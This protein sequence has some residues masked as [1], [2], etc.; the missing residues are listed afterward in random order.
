MTKTPVILVLRRYDEFGLLLKEAGYEVISLAVLKTKPTEDLSGLRSRLGKLSDYDGLFF[1]SPAAAEVFVNE[2]NEKNG[3][4]GNVY[5]LGQRA[6]SILEVAGYRVRKS[7][8][9]N[10]AEEL[11]DAFD[12][13]E[14]T[15]KRFLFVRGERSIRTI[16]EK[17]NGKAAVDEVIV[18]TTE[19]PDIDKETQTFIKKR[20][21]NDGIDFVCFF[22]PSGVERFKKV[23]GNAARKTSAAAIGNTTAEAARRAG[24][25]VKYISPKSSA[26]DFATGLI[27]HIN[28]SD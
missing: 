22:S 23:F 28:H 16:P 18:Y 12:S 2:Q 27:E 14:F 19:A 6:R 25:E 26:E 11:L 17:L 13:S 20:L 15:G 8:T 9:A 7:D 21:S 24:F 5:A 4:S 1:T 3:F 10:T